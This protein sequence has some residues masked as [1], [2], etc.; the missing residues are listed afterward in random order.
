MSQPEKLTLCVFI[1]AL[2]WEVA[3]RYP[4]LEDIL[5]ERRPLNTIF[6]YSSTC[7]PTI[8]TGAL[9]R[10]HGHFA[11]FA[12]APDRSPFKH[13]KYFRLLPTSIMQRGRV[14]GKLSQ[15]MKRV[16]G[17]TGYFQLYNM[18]FKWLHLFTYT[19]QN[20][21]FEPGGIN[22]GQPT[23]FD[24]LRDNNIPYCR[25]EG[26][27]EPESVAEVEAA[28]DEGAV[29]FVYL[30]LGRLDAILH[31]YGAAGDPVKQHIAWYEGEIRRIYEKAAAQYS[32]VHLY[33]FSDHGMTDIRQTCD[34]MARIESLGLAFGEDYAAAYD[35][36]M[37]RFWFLKPGAREK[38]EAAL[39][40]EPLGHT[41]SAEELASY[42]CDFP[43]NTYGDLFFLMNPGVLIC[44]SH[45]GVK[46]LAGMHG[47][48]PGDPDSVAALL[49]NV[50]VAPEITGLEHLYALMRREVENQPAR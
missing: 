40:E 33:I 20:N 18:P 3:K 11:F 46:P 50:P 6:G 24:Y 2:G 41:M 16:H 8:L 35:S 22:G 14:R 27:N 21:I 5:V 38:I 43:G 48:A 7:D 19:E 39:A 29:S 26:Y 25:P 30:F 13:Y 1:D 36:T 28:I 44:P 42:G 49:A 4:M 9:P 34:V 15:I 32:E 12:Y 23:I 10:D 45:M 47:F 37:A 31:Q 17:F